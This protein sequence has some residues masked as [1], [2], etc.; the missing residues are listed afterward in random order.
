MPLTMSQDVQALA[1]LHATV[2]KLHLIQACFF[3][4]TIFLQDLSDLLSKKAEVLGVINE[5]I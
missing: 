3:P 4:T 2:H 5:I 1:F